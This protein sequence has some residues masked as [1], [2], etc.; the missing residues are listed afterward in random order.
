MDIDYGKIVTNAL[1][2]LVATVF[3]G[4]AVIVW[5]AST[6]LDQRIEEANV[7][8]KGQQDCLQEQQASIKEQQGSIQDQQGTIQATQETLIPEV[9]AIRTKVDDIENQ[10]KSI[11]QILSETEATK[12]KVSFDPNR[13][14]MLKQYRDTARLDERIE[15][16]SN[17][18]NRAI[19]TKQMEYQK[20]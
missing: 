9:A 8:I 11:T 13:P 18:I 19:D 16:E 5:N 14:F 12:T 1:S 17:R 2:A 20:K 7:D 15:E 10:L 4:A 3:V 6:S